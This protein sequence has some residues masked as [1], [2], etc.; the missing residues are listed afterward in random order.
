MADE[1]LLNG[2]GTKNSSGAILQA[3]LLAGLAAL[4][5]SGAAA[6]G[7]ER[8]ERRP[9]GAAC[10]LPSPQDIVAA[11]QGY[12][13]GTPVKPPM[14]AAFSATQASLLRLLGSGLAVLFG[15][16]WEFSRTAGSCFGT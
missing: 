12:I 9:A 7:L 16:L 13:F 6:A 11:A 5:P 8:G 1:A 14:P 15:C 4:D 10:L 3:S 2:S